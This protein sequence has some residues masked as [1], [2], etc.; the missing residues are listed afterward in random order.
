MEIKNITPTIK[1]TFML[2]RA[3]GPVPVTLEIGFVS[4]GDVADFLPVKPVPGAPPVRVGKVIQKILIDAVVGWD[5]T[6][7]GEPIPCSPEEKAAILPVLLGVQ[8]A[9]DDDPGQVDGT[10]GWRLFAEASNDA[11][12]LGG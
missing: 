1:R 6:R 12:F 10:L 4:P 9:A 8:V 7:N 5:L 3:S 11:A 2:V